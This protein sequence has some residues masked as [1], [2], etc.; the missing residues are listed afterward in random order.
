MVVN[1]KIDAL[2]ENENGFALITVLMLLSILS[3]I[4][5]AAF[6]TSK[7]EL[8]IAGN[9]RQEKPI[10]YG[11]E[12]G[13]WRAGQWLRNLQMV[14][15]DNY[16]DANLEA[17]FQASGNGTKPVRDVNATEESIRSENGPTIPVEYSYRI[18]DL[19]NCRPIPG[20]NPDIL[21]CYFKVDCSSATPDGGARTINIK[22]GKPTDFK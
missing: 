12:S 16:V 7:T 1:K 20:C 11:A 9:E 22:V 17:L 4:A 6:N 21:R 10:F 13:C 3:V 19:Q 15:V 14:V 5:I 18:G 8:R 2:F